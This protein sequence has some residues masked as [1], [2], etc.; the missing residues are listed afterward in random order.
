MHRRYTENRKEKHKAVT[1]S[2]EKDNQSSF[3]TEFSSG[4]IFTVTVIL[5]MNAIPLKHVT[6]SL[7]V[8]VEDTF[9]DLS[10]RLRQEIVPSYTHVPMIM[11][12]L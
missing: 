3:N 11:Y 6:A 8:T 10:R 2:R 1:N 4:A 7:P 5:I 12:S 9:R